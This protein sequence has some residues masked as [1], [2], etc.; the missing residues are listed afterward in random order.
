MGYNKTY[1]CAYPTSPEEH[2]HMKMRQDQNFERCQTNKAENWMYEKLEATDYKWRRQARWGTRIYDFWCSK[3][4]VAVE[5]D[6]I[7][8]DKGYDSRHDRY[9]LERS[10][11]KV[12][13]IRNFNEEDAK[14]ALLEI[15]EACDWNERRRKHGLKLL[16]NY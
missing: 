10:G 14:N 6:G 3:I 11:I 15:A 8:H 7:T 4:G 12:I 13:R 1:G 2:A 16:T 9:N 5:V